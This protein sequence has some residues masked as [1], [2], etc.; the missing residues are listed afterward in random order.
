MDITVVLKLSPANRVE[1][2]EAYVRR[3]LEAKL[4]K[5]ETRWGK[6]ITAR[7]VAEEQPSGFSTTLA[8]MGETEMVAK[9]F[10][11]KLPKAVDLTVNK[12][13]RQFEIAAEMREGRERQRRT[14][15]AK[16]AEF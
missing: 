4:S 1:A 15:L 9:A 2:T 14:T 7:L 5:I 13:V 10:D 16:P 12:M 6:P 11:L 8:L 3:H